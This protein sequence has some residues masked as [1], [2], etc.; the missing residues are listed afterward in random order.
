MKKTY[1]KQT[2][3]GACGDNLTWALDD[4]GTLTISGSGAMTNWRS[5]VLRDISSIKNVVINTG[6]TSIGDFAFGGC[7]S[8]TSIN[9]PSSVTSIGIFAFFG[10]ENLTSIN[11][12]NE[13]TRIECGTFYDCKSLTSINIPS[14]VTYIEDDAFG[15]CK[16]LT[17]VYY[18]GT[19]AEWKGIKIDDRNEAII[20][21]TIHYNTLENK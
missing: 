3:S 19:E 16:S 13:V 10:C 20:N 4:K 12:P 11:I 2:T 1:S 18:G 17:D 8:L 9:I 7:E 14:S 21:A 15:E 5:S 6:V